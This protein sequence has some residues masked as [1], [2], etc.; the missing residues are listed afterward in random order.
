MMIKRLDIRLV[1]VGSG[2]LPGYHG[3]MLRGVLG[4]GIRSAACIQGQST[5]CATCE[6]AFQCPYV[7]LFSH[8]A[9]DLPNT[10]PNPFVLHPRSRD[11]RKYESGDSLDFRLTL[12][13]NAVRDISYYLHAF[14][15]S[16]EIPL[17]TARIPFRVD[18]IRDS[19]LDAAVFEKGR[20]VFENLP[21]IRFTPA[22]GTAAAILLKY[23]TPMRLMKDGRLVDCP[24]FQDILQ[25]TIRRLGMTSKLFDAEDGD[26]Y[27]GADTV[28]E[29]LLKA[30]EIKTH[31]SDLGWYH[32]TRQSLAK[33]QMTS[34]SG[35]IGTQEFEGN[36]TPFIPWL[37]LGSV[38]H[39][40][41][42]T[43]MGCGHF[44]TTIIASDNQN[45][46]KGVL[47]QEVQ[48]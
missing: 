30:A 24:K 39:I 14:L 25:A 26:I 4:R 38:L 37:Q 47:L 5:D 12:F 17:G 10:P 34:I 2:V 6:N 32:L 33:S 3:S 22:G 35:F 21:G 16:N 27:P 11:K 36:L 15:A 1:A 42:G 8:I 43:T 18:S 20:L 44:E 46:R 41:K 7:H 9:P 23:D 13:G 28:H 40:G 31:R 19:D 45:R 29:L 48:T